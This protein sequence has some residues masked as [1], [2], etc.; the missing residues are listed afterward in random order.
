MIEMNLHNAGIP[1]ANLIKKVEDN[2]LNDPKSSKADKLKRFHSPRR[3]A[4][5][6]SSQR[7]ERSNSTITDEGLVTDEASS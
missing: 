7:F 2:L 5:V 4:I 3:K 6:A 1:L